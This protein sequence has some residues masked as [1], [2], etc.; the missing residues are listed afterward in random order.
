MTDQRRKLTE[1]DVREIIQLYESGDY[2]AGALSR[3]FGVARSQ[4]SMILTGR[5]W[6]SVTGGVHRSRYTAE[7]L[8]AYQQQR[9]AVSDQ[10]DAAVSRIAAELDMSTPDVWAHVRMIARYPSTKGR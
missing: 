9:A 4:I 5:S 6:R 1:S 10:L 7:Q 8:T 2:S 3:Q